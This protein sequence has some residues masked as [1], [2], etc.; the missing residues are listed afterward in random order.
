MNTRN[1]I[2]NDDLKHWFAASLLKMVAVLYAAIDVLDNILQNL[3]HDMKIKF[4]GGRFSK[5]INSDV[6]D[7]QSKV[8]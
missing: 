7:V 1:W 3:V 4:K 8:F 2:Y 5:Q 6:T